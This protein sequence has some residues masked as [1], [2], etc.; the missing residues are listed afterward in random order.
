MT[1]LELTPKEFDGLLERLGPS[2]QEWARQPMSGGRFEIRLSP[3]CFWVDHDDYEHHQLRT[4]LHHFSSKWKDVL[5]EPTLVKL[6]A[7][8]AAAPAT[9]KRAHAQEGT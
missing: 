3:I 9:T 8:L 5:T 6:R 1:D 7:L 4:L 2:H